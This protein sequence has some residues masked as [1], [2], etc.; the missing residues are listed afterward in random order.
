MYR[1]LKGRLSVPE[2]SLGT[3]RMEKTHTCPPH[4]F[5]P[6]ANSDDGQ[7]CAFLC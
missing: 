1:E 2:W 6:K 5:F 4:N 3:H 7:G